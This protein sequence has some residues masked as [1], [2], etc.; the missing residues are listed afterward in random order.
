MCAAVLLEHDEARSIHP[1]LALRDVLAGNL[2]RTLN[3]SIINGRGAPKQPLELS[4]EV[5]DPQLQSADG[6]SR[7]TMKSPRTGPRGHDPV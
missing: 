7:S 3:G 6:L 1:E 2:A 4:L 5:E